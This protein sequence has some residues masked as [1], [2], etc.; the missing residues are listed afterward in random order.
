MPRMQ[1]V[2][3]RLRADVGLLAGA[4]IVAV[5]AGGL[6]PVAVAQKPAPER[7]CHDAPTV[8]RGE[9]SRFEWMARTKARANWRHKVR[10]MPGLG[11]A[12]SD[13]KMAANLEESCLSG[14]AGTLCTI[15]AVP[16]RK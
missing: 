12:Y 9:P 2:A 10:S 8:A 3:S 7:T 13:W 5:A 4:A 16:C 1:Q 14:P 6:P 11:T 15:S